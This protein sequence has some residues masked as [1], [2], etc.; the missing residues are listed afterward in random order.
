M[1]TKMAIAKYCKLLK[2]FWD[3]SKQ[4]SS[5]TRKHRYYQLHTSYIDSF[6]YVF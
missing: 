1:A 4:H 2:A 6:P 3:H 5:L